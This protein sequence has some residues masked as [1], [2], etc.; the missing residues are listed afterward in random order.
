MN[1]LN[2]DI[3]T[4]IAELVGEGV[5]SVTEMRRHIRMYVEKELFDGGSVPPVTDAAYHPKE[6]TI[7]KH[8]YLAQQK[9]RWNVHYVLE[10]SSI[11]AVE[12]NMYM[13]HF[14]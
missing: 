13:F 4:K 7:R 14:L 5:S 3:R 12:W 11:M 8:M 9:L 6:E 1:P 10:G 2:K